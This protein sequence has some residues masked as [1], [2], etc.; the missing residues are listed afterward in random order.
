VPQSTPFWVFIIVSCTYLSHISPCNC[1]RDRN[2]VDVSAVYHQLLDT[3]KSSDTESDVNVE[4]KAGPS[5]SRSADN[6][7]TTTR[8][9]QEQQKRRMSRRRT[10][11]AAAIPTDWRRECRDLLEMLWSCEDSTP[12]RLPFTQNISQKIALVL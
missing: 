6:L 9:H 4:A 2:D 1:S 8:K 12:F 3:Y 7:G 5:S 11:A 10:A